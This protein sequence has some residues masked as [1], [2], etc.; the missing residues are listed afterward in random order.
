M[1][2]TDSHHPNIRSEESQSIANRS[3]SCSGSNISGSSLSQVKAYNILSKIGT[4]FS[5]G[6]QRGDLVLV[7]CVHV[8]ARR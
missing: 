3:C 4:T 7:L 5:S 1:Q 8:T 6:V 2:K